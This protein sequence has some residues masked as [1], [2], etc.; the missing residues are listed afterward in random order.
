MNR[1]QRRKSKTGKPAAQNVSK[2]AS[3][4]QNI[5]FMI[6]AKILEIKGKEVHMEKA[7]FDASV[8]PANLCK[9]LFTYMRL[10]DKIEESAILDILD[11]ESGQLIASYSTASGPEFY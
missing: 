3:L 4:V 2:A 8:N 5:E 10:A 9:N 7:V 1:R 6:H 11:L